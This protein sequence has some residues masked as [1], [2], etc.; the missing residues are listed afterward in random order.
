MATNSKKHGAS[1]RSKDD[2]ISIT[3][4]THGRV[5]RHADDERCVP[6]LGFRSSKAGR[7]RMLNITASSTRTGRVRIGKAA[8]AWRVAGL[9]S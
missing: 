7:T 3:I 2:I 8:A 9:A 4:I 5:P 1:Q 6:I